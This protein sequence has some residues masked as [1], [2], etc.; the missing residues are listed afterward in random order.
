MLCKI[1]YYDG[2]ANLLNL[3]SEYPI[4]NGNTAYLPVLSNPPSVRE[5]RDA[6]L[7]GSSRKFKQ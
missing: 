5:K 4:V 3:L 2:N 1:S 7:G 6:E